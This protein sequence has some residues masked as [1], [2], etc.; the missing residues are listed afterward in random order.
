MD[1]SGLPIE[2]RRYYPFTA[3]H[4]LICVSFQNTL[5]TVGFAQNRFADLL[6]SQM[7]NYIDVHIES[8]SFN[9]EHS[10]VYTSPHFQ[11]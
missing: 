2:R 7:E 6:L 9:V 5:H 11:K 8:G 1:A 4:Q 10:F 3:N